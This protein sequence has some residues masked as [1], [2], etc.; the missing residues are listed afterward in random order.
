M[1]E[2]GKLK[3]ER[4][5]GTRG[6]ETGGHEELLFNVYRVSVLHDEKSSENE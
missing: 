5:A 6:W 1:E 2:K 3:T 4:M